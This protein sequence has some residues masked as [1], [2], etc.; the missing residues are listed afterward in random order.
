MLTS[1]TVNLR[2]CLPTAL[3]HDTSDISLEAQTLSGPRMSGF[4]S[5]LIPSW[6]T[7]V[8]NGP[9]ERD[10]WATRSSAQPL[11][12][13]WRRCWGLS[14]F[15]GR[16]MWL[17]TVAQGTVGVGLGVSRAN[18][19]EKD[20]RRKSAN[21]DDGAELWSR[22]AGFFTSIASSH[23]LPVEKACKVVLT[24]GEGDFVRVTS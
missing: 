15:C 7:A 2:I 14:Y 8:M 1:G 5:K 22:E 24:F 6:R 20:T 11:R 21:R 12:F 17:C 16:K 9:G 23:R 3:I 13:Q 4:W 10:G 18:R 19:L